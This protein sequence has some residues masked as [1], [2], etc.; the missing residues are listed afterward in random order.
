M[1][2]KLLFLT[3]ASIILV[4]ILNF[5]AMFYYFYWI[6]GWFDNVV[7]F[8]GGFAIGLLSIWI[9]FQSGLFKKIVPEKRQAILTSI[10]CVLVIGVGW[11][12]FEN[13]NGLTQSTESYSLDI[14]HDLISD[15]IGSVVAGGLAVNKKLYG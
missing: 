15:F 4:A 8:F 14:V 1:R 10:A 11:E 2:H 3:L 12:I 5:A 13:L 7:H 6:F 9:Y